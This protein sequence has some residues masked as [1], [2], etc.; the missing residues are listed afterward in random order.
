[1]AVLRRGGFGG[2]RKRS[3]IFHLTEEMAN[4]EDEST[5]KKDSKI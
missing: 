3:T 4:F 1:M 5:G 2:D